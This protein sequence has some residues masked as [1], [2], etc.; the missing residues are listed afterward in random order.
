[1]WAVTFSPVMVGFHF[2]GLH[3]SLMGQNFYFYCFGDSSP[4]SWFFM[5]GS[6]I[7]LILRGDSSFTIFNRGFVL[8]VMDSSMVFSVVVYPLSQ[9]RFVC[10]DYRRFVSI[11]IAWICPLLLIKLGFMAV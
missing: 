8:N 5:T 4:T 7:L 1:M 2:Y 11:V 10:S 9:G 6:L 3:S